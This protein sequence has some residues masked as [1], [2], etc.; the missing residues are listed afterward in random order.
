MELA[1]KLKIL[2]D[3]AKYDVSCVSSGS[4]RRNTSGG[5]GS[6]MPAGICHSFASDGRCISLLK[7]LMSNCCIY[8]CA[9]CVNRISNDLP[10][11]TF[12]PAEIADL[13]INFYRRNYIEGLFLSSAVVKNP[14]YTMEQIYIAIRLLR[15][16]YRFNGYIH[17]KAIPGAD[18]R[19]VEMTGCLA[20][21]MSVNIELPTSSGLKMLAPQKDK[22]SILGPMQYISSR[23][24]ESK[25]DYINSGKSYQYLNGSSQASYNSY[26]YTEIGRAHV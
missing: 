20:D 15:E 11:T 3:S 14:D 26:K 24:A 8:D 2:A 5:I 6:A 10:R 13:T 18:R 19:L 16:E 25:E 17:V 12:T 4:S 21:R 1:E 9:Y 7:I 23:I 22:A